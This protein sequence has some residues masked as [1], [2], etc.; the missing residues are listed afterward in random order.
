MTALDV[1]VFRLAAAGA[2]TLPRRR[3]RR[4]PHWLRIA[5]EVLTGLAVMVAGL[6][7][8]FGLGS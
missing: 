1:D 2:L 5:E 3:Y 7:A 6:V 8:G 4:R